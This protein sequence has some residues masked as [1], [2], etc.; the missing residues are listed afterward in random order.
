MRVATSVRGWQ[1]VHIT[2]VEF[3]IVINAVCTRRAHDLKA[4]HVFKSCTQLLSARPVAVPYGP[5]VANDCHCCA[6]RKMIRGLML[7]ASRQGVNASSFSTWVHRKYGDF[8]VL[9]ILQ[10]GGYGTSL[11][12]VMCRKAL[13]R[14]CI[15]WRAHIG[16]KW[17]RSTDEHVPR[18][19]PTSR[20][21]TTLGF[22]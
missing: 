6:E 11:P 4:T 15:Q 9:R 12:C 21:R 22:L 5:S 20:Q 18:S 17:V 3:G 13:D 1:R 16:P 14:L 19:R 7:K 2:D 10:D 8:V